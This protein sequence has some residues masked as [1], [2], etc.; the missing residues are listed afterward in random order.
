M[1]EPTKNYDAYGAFAKLIRLFGRP[2][3][4]QN[5]RLGDFEE[6]FVGFFKALEPEDFLVEVDVFHL[7]IATYDVL[8]LMRQQ[9]ALLNEWQ[10]KGRLEWAKFSTEGMPNEGMREFHGKN[11]HIAKTDPQYKNALAQLQEAANAEYEQE[12][13]R[14][15]TD[16]DY[17]HVSVEYSALVE[18]MDLRINRALKRRDDILRQIAGWRLGLEKKL[19]EVSDAIIE[20]TDVLEATAGAM[21]LIEQGGLDGRGG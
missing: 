12:I 18:K 21:A 10:N 2:P 7:T 5:E 8:R 1:R 16:L 20:R 15:V 6:V 17:V 9:A 3:L 4:L 19:R 14:P 13:N 11:P